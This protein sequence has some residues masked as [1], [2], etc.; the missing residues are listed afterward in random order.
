MKEKIAVKTVENLKEAYS[1]ISKGFDKTRQFDWKEFEKYLEFIE[2]N[3]EILDIGCGNGR[4]FKFISSKRK[5]KYTGIDNNVE[6]LKAAKQQNKTKFIEASMLKLPFPSEKFDVAVAIASVHHLPSSKMR[7]KAIKE[8]NRI[9]KKDGI[10]IISVWNFFQKKYRNLI[11]KARLKFISSL[12]K[13]GPRDIF[14]PWAH[15]GIE[16]Y[17]YAFKMKELKK[18]M[19]LNGFEIIYEKISRNFLLICK[20]KQ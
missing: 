9:L 18:I 16:R 12:F 17:Y 10:L 2:N 19:K 1:K 14:K 4:F 3:D 20:K 13:Y 6:L 11:W 15:T 7:K 8:A 5:I